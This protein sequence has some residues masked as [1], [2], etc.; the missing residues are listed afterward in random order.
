MNAA[1][2]KQSTCQSS[3]KAWTQ[4][5]T[6]AA[7]LHSAQLITSTVHTCSKHNQH[8]LSSACNPGIPNPGIPRS[9]PFSPIPNPQTAASQSSDFRITKIWL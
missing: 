1:Y 3:P 8:I 5:P 2:T 7:F 9:R 4:L 6:D